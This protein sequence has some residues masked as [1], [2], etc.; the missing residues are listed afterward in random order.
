VGLTLALSKLGLR[1]IFNAKF[2]H[3]A[4]QFYNITGLKRLSQT[5]L[6]HFTQTTCQA[7]KYGVVDFRV[8]TYP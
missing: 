4:D 8:K 2:F 7:L 1:L 6:L 3:F 5:I